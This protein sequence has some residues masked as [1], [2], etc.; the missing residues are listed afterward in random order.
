MAREMQFQDYYEVLGVPREAPA[1]DVKKAYR[2]LAMKWHPDQHLGEGAAEAEKRFK[3]ISEAYEVLSDPEKRARYDKFGQH[4][5]HGQ[6]FEP[7]PGGRKMSREEF[8]GTFGG[9]GFSD[10][11]QGMFGDQVRQDFGGRPRPHARYQHRG[12]DARAELHLGIGDALAGG[13]R[14]FTIPTRQ[15]CPAC[16]G[17]GFLQEHVCP[18]CAGVGQVSRSRQVDLKIPAAVRDGMTLRLAGLG[19]PGAGGGAAGDLHLVLRLD[20]DG[21]YRLKDGLLEAT[22][23]I[24]PAE[25]VAG[26]KVDVRTARG[27]VALTIP[28]DS[29]GGKRLRLRGQGLTRANGEP[30][31]VDVVLEIALPADLTERQRELLREFAAAGTGA[32]RGGARIDG[33]TQ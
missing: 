18:T 26:G 21:T 4:W 6:E 10:F 19:E 2:K 3:A 16:G 12:A 24:S 7:E 25:A 13:K 15:S 14:S 29:R 5:E 31:D 8:E 28:P 27:V 11:F 33:G 17:T 9:G 22:V 32:V 20:D 1:K 30:G 23:P